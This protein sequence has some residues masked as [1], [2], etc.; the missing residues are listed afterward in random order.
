DLYLLTFSGYGLRPNSAG[1][2]PSVRPRRLFESYEYSFLYRNTRVDGCTL[3]A[4]PTT[5]TSTPGSGAGFIIKELPD[6]RYCDARQNTIEPTVTLPR[7]IPRLRL[8][9]NRI[10][11]RLV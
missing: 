10:N 6:D 8:L 4:D 5:T 7:K 9:L 2:S 11:Q 1:Y 3:C